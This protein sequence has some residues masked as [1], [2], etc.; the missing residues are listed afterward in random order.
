MLQQ[1][2]VPG[3][4]EMKNAVLF[5]QV[6]FSKATSQHNTPTNY[7][8][9]ACNP[10]PSFSI[11][12]K[13]SDI[14]KIIRWTEQSWYIQIFWRTTWV[15]WMSAMWIQWKQLT[16]ADLKAS[17]LYNV[18]IKNAEHKKIVI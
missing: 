5:H 17:K 10:A 12:V 13:A 18:Q 11:E 3:G 9:I 1:W 8:N 4:E 2:H 7:M 15:K 16:E 6:K 14:D